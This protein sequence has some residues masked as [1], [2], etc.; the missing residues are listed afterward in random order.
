MQSSGLLARRAF[1][2]TFATCLL[3]IVSTHSGCICA[4]R[5]PPEAERDFGDTKAPTPDALGYLALARAVLEK[6][7]RSASAP[8]P[9]PGRRVMLALFSRAQ[10]FV[11]TADG[12]TLAEAVTGA[13]ESI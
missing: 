6:T 7:S 10:T 8:P 13:A 1:V 11:G 4:P 3:A 2:G 9:A 12:P 5:I